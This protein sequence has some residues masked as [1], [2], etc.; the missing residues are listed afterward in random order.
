[1]ETFLMRAS[2]ILFGL[3]V[4]GVAIGTATY[5]AWRTAMA[6]HAV[7]GYKLGGSHGQ[8]ACECTRGGGRGGGYKTRCHC[9]SCAFSAGDHHPECPCPV[10]GAEGQ[11]C[12]CDCEAVGTEGDHY[13]EMILMGACLSMFG[14]AV[15][16]LTFGAAT[17]QKAEPSGRND[18]KE[19]GE[20][21]TGTAISIHVLR[22][23]GLHERG[24]LPLPVL[25]VDAS[26]PKKPR[27]DR[28][29]A[30]AQQRHGGAY[31]PQENAGPRVRGLRDSFPHFQNDCEG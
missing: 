4:V 20:R 6:T 29:R 7:T 10:C 19:S 3:V 22:I 24:Q 5:A 12:T 14:L 11:E 23:E 16:C 27:I 13:M 9:R 2:M 18:K 21:A 31:G 1:M 8:P 30:R 15:A 25:H 17:Q 26:P 28:P